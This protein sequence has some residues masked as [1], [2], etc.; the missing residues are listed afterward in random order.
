VHIFQREQDGRF[1]GVSRTLLEDFCAASLLS[2][3]VIAWAS[4]TKETY[5]L[6][7][8]IRNFLFTPVAVA[9]IFFLCWKQ[10]SKAAFYAATVLFFITAYA[11]VRGVLESGSADIFLSGL[12]FFLAMNLALILFFGSVSHEFF[13]DRALKFFIVVVLCVALSSIVFG[14]LQLSFPPRFVLEAS[15]FGTDSDLAYS[16]GGSK[17]YGLAAIAASLLGKKS[18]AAVR[19]FYLVLVGLFLLLCAVGGGRGEF[20]AVFF[21]VFAIHGR[22]GLSVLL[23]LL[24]LTV[25]SFAF[26]SS[27]FEQFFIFERFLGFQYSLGLR[28]VLFADAVRLLGNEPGCFTFGCGVG[29]FQQYYG[30]PASLYPHNLVL[31]LFIVIGVF[32]SIL[33]FVLAAA[34]VF[35]FEKVSSVSNV[36]AYWIFCFF[37]LIGLKSGAVL[38]SWFFTAPLIFFVGCAFC[39]LRAG[40]LKR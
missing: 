4:T 23:I 19:W 17:F 6:F 20:A 1:V 33:V 15:V 28:D 34:G 16:Q 5:A 40:K 22:L 36:N 37:L 18:I 11:T 10:F 2:L 35:W 12:D 14:G 30:Y 29:Y 39:F 25:F 21:V 26:L 8:F 7:G 38:T 27:F 3:S 24:G 9:A 32:A 31:E 13:S